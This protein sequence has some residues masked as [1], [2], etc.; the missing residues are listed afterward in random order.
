M[1]RIL[2]VEDESVAAWYL[3][4]ALE[5]MGHEVVDSAS[6]GEE[7]LYVIAET[8]P[9]LV[10]MDIRLAGQIDGIAAA[11]QIHS[12]FNIPVVYLTAHADDATL[13]R[14]ITT[15]PFGYLVKPFQEREVHTTIEIALRRHQL[16]K[17][18]E[19]TKQWFANTLNS[20]GDATIATDHDGNIIF[21]NPAASTLTGWSESEAMGKAA[22]TVLPLIHAQTRKEIE[23]PLLQAMRENT[24]V[25]LPDNCLLRNKGGTETPIGDIA[26]PMRNSDGEIIGSVAV[27]QDET[28]RRQTSSEIQQRNLTL[29]LTQASLI[30]R[31]QERTVQLQ[32]A[33]ACT[34]VLK[35][36]LAQVDEGASQPK[37]FQTVIQELGRVLEAD[38]CW[39]TLYSANHTLATISGEYIAPDAINNYPSALGTQINIQGFPDFYRRL[40]DRGYLLSSSLAVLPAPYSFLQTPSSQFL[41][42]PL[43][44]EEVVIGEVGILSTGKSYIPQLQVELISEVINQ[45]ASVLR[46]AHSYRVTQDYLG[47]LKLLNELKAE[48]IDT[49][50]HELCTPLTNMRMAVEMLSTLVKSLQSHD[51]ETASPSNRQLVWQRLEEYLQ[52]LREQW[53]REFDLISDLLNFQSLDTLT[54][55]FPLTPIDLQQWLPQLVKHFSRKRSRQEHSLKCNVFLDTPTIVSHEPSLRRIITELLTNACKFSP[56][57]SLIEVIAEAVDENVVIK[58]TNDGVT[59]PPGEL[60]RIFQPFYRIPRPNLWDYSG[61][62]LGL[63]MVKKLV[64]LLG[65]E[66]QVK[67]QAQET[68]FTVILFQFH[69]F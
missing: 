3:Q 12:R 57:S 37:L 53:Q 10:L 26:T 9:D 27:F 21:M 31:L 54:E 2:I 68:T 18:Q 4:E 7:A 34:Q 61:T 20:I 65:G 35:R 49:I 48:F 41:V 6:S 19:D 60:N 36:V 67:S 64:Q 13:T 43:V 39:I 63:A 44:E 24:V 42:I 55:S 1:A 15:N 58:V 45:C 16:E 29:E 50:S 11:E 62:G 46:Q 56:P 38:Y 32:Q 30:A 47:D 59:I 69:T 25:R 28:L 51:I 22:A 14:A 40:L 5:S 33:L 17:R 8:R 23:N 66:I 52:V